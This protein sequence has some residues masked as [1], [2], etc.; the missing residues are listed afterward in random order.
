MVPENEEV[1]QESKAKE[2]FRAILLY[3]GRG[4]LDAKLKSLMDKAWDLAAGTLHHDA[5]GQAA[6]FAVAQ[7]TILVIR[8]LGV[9]QA[10]LDDQRR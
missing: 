5:A 8:T 7:A 2:R 9:I 10:D 1:P 4:S 3:Y 6:T